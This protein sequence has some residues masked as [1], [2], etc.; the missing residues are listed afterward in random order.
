LRMLATRDGNELTHFLMDFDQGTRFSIASWA[1]E[2]EEKKDKTQISNI[3]ARCS[4]LVMQQ[5]N[6]NYK[7]LAEASLKVR[8][9]HSALDEIHSTLFKEREKNSL[10][11]PKFFSSNTDDQSILTLLEENQDNISEKKN[12]LL[13]LIEYMLEFPNNS[14]TEPIEE[15]VKEHPEFLTGLFTQ[16]VQDF[17]T[18]IEYKQE[19]LFFSNQLFCC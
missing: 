13:S 3:T 14:I 9:L 8:Q 15:Y 10:S 4:A 16:Q 18:W 5:L 2:K 19:E 12:G 11:G 6:D 17:I 1:F 7:F